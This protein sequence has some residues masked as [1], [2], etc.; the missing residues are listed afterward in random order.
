MSTTAIT[1][2]V[3]KKEYQPKDASGN[4]VGPLQV[5]EGASWQEV[6]DKLAQAHEHASAKIQ[7][8]RKQVKPDAES[9]VSEFKAK[10]L[11]ADELFTIQQDMQDPSKM[12][13]ALRKLNEAEFGAP[14]PKI[15][16]ALAKVENM[17][18]V[19]QG[20]AES[21]KFIDAHPEYHACAENQNAI[22]AFMTE[23]NNGKA[24]AWTKRN[25]D[26]AYEAVHDKL[27]AKPAATT[28]TTEVISSTVTRPRA[29]TTALF[30]QHS[31][32]S[33]PTKPSL[34]QFAQEVAKM[35][36]AEYRRRLMSE[37]GFAQ[38]V[39]DLAKATR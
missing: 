8:L 12:R 15:R 5:F 10:D 27:V 1:P 2:E 33:G 19:E 11:T 30:S 32:A 9:A 16:E 24:F 14:A 34:D 23:G 3:F 39:N 28:A 17:E 21:Q 29:T 6:T 22:Q 37:P 36:S 38:K 20:K 18:R 35:P 13:D 7:E 25:L 31:S 26:I 4:P